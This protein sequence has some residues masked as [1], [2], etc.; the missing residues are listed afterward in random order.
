MKFRIIQFLSFSIIGAGGFFLLM[1]VYTSFFTHSL[2]KEQVDYFLL[3]L[4]FFYIY[5]KYLNNI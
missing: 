1:Q 4:S 2:G 3:L 5:F